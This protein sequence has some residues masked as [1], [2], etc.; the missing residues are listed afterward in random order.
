MAQHYAVL[1]ANGLP[2]AFYNDEIYP[3]NADGTE[4]AAIPAAAV[5]ITEAQWQDCIANNG[6]RQIVNGVLVVYTPPAPAPV[7]PETITEHQFIKQLVIGGD[8]TPAEGIAFLSTGAI[9]P[10]FAN[11]IAQLPTANQSMAELDLVGAKTFD[12]H[13]A[14]VVVLGALMGKTPA[15]LDAIWTAAAL[16]S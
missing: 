5:A 10:L 12:R 6:R 1:D 15:E 8:I 13:N 14:V 9:P 7:V 4:N 11:A 3:P 2:T 16:L